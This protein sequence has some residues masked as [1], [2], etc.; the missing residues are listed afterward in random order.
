MDAVER[1]VEVY[2]YEGEVVFVPSGWHHQV[3]NLVCGLYNTDFFCK[4]KPEYV[5]AAM[6]LCDTSAL[7]S[8]RTIFITRPIAMLAWYVQFWLIPSSSLNST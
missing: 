4:G 5:S 8:L 6:S 2:Q 1:G 3:F 7:K